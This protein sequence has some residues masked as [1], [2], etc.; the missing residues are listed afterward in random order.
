MRVV[1]VG[2]GF[3]NKGAEA[4]L[5]TLRAELGRRVGPLEVVVW[6]TAPA[7]VALAERCGFEW[8]TSTAPAGRVAKVGWLVRQCMRHPAVVRPGIGGT[9]A[10]ALLIR[11]KGFEMLQKVGPYDAV[12]DAS[13]FAYGDELGVHAMTL[14][15]PLARSAGSSGRPYVFLPQ[16]WGPFAEHK[17]ARAITSLLELPGAFA[18]A[19]DN[20]SLGHLAGVCG[21]DHR[22]A[23]PRQD[24]AFAFAGA[25][26]DVGVRIL[27]NL[28]HTQSRPVVGLA[29]NV[30]AYRRASDVMRGE[31]LSG[32]VTLGRTAID[33]LD[34]DVLL[35]ANEIKPGRRDEDDRGLCELVAHEIDRPGR[36]LQ[37]HDELTAEES[38]SVIGRCDFVFASRYHSLV[39]AL[40][41]GV[42]CAALGWTHKYAELLRPFGL[43][44][45]EARIGDS[46]PAALR[47]MLLDGWANRVETRQRIM[48]QRRAVASDNAALFDEIA[49]RLDGS[50]AATHSR[51]EAD[52]SGPAVVDMGQDRS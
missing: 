15:E 9:S 31:Y 38:K 29:P 51:P 22:D 28:G 32:L 18:Y 36:V 40:S 33:E 42:P 27:T 52:V 1:V 46:S 20:V 23:M 7:E 4:M 48:E 41:Q 47:D 34:C 3:A 44:K 2:V 26:D 11:A 6:D 45:A 14:T 25:G 16:A 49:A 24:T 13:G 50:R 35:A 5:K 19:R 8:V 43:E 37:S 21:I 30:R 39:F 12:L 10:L 17:V